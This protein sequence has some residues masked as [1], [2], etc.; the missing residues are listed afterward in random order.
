MFKS[1]LMLHDK[2]P[3]SGIAR[4]GSYCLHSGGWKRD[5]TLLLLRCVSWDQ[6][7]A[8]RLLSL[9]W[10]HVTLSKIIN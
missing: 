4:S 8:A 5:G 7:G 3:L 10:L 9:N 6:G 1:E 2:H